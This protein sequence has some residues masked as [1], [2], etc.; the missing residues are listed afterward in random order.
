LAVILACKLTG[1]LWL[2]EINLL[3]ERLWII[4]Q[5]A[6]SYA[7]GLNS[8]SVSAEALIV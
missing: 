1:S 2:D 7:S 6:Q 5:T 8:D 4:T 3:F